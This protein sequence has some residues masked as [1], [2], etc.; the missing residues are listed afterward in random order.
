MTMSE[1]VLQE[2]ALAEIDGKRKDRSRPHDLSAPTGGDIEDCELATLV[3]KVDSAFSA[4]PDLGDRMK[5]RNCLIAKHGRGEGSGIPAH[6]GRAFV[7][8]FD[9]NI[10]V[11]AAWW[12]KILDMR[13]AE[14]EHKKKLQALH[15]REEA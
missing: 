4:F 13:R 1:I 7:G 9:A 14:A 10:A 5:V 11:I 15:N 8:H 12:S 3:A 2:W 6:I